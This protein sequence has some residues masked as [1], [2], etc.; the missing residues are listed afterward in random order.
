M[1]MGF[2]GFVVLLIF[3]RTIMNVVIQSAEKWR[4]MTGGK[5]L[6]FT[7]VFFVSFPPLIGFSSL[8]TLT[9]LIWGF[10]HGWWVL[11]SSSVIGSACSFVLFKYVL[12]ERARRLMETSK[13]FELF[14]LVLNDKNALW[15]LAAIRLCP[16][17]YSF[18][19]GALAAIPG[20]KVAVFVLASVITSPKLLIP[21]FIGSKLQDIGQAKSGSEVAVDIFSILLMVT[22]F[23]ATTLVLYKK[24]QDKLATI[25]SGLNVTV[26]DNGNLEIEGDGDLLLDDEF[27]EDNLVV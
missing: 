24:M 12:K 17:P 5:L 8:C 1:V 9:G 10:P 11:A 18:S 23:S 6:M 14:T 19:N 15:L 7:L 21:I 2:I 4:N 27:D 25:N 20:V 13:T 22:A 3:H 16:L 26:D